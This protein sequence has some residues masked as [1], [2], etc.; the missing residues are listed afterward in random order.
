MQ[1][2]ADQKKFTADL[3]KVLRLPSTAFVRIVEVRE[4]EDTGRAMVMFDL[5]PTPARSTDKI[6][7][8]LAAL[9]PQARSEVYGGDI[10]QYLDRT[11]MEPALVRIAA[12][13]ASQQQVPVPASGSIASI[14]EV[15]THGTSAVSYVGLLAMLVVLVLVLLAYVKGITYYAMQLFD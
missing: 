2:E 8:Q 9:L 11:G 5:H 3:A 15:D 6:I 1:C 4:A 7:S 12:D 14:D 13:G 10:T